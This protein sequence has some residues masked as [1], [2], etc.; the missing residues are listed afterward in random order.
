MMLFSIQVKNFLQ[1]PESIGCEI[2]SVSVKSETKLLAYHSLIYGLASLFNRVIGFIMIPVYT[3]FF[4]PSDYGMLEIITITTQVIGLVASVGVTQSIGRFYFQYEDS[5]DRNEVLSTGIIAFSL[6]SLV[7]LLPMLSLSNTLSTWLL[8]ST[9][10]SY[11]FVIAIG[12]IWFSTLNEIGFY[13]FRMLKQSIR[14]MVLSIIK[15]L[16]SILLN[17]YF[18]VVMKT[19]IIGVLYST[20]IASVIFTIILLIP[21]LNKI[22]YHFS[23]F[24]LKEMLRF[25]LPLIPSSLANMV[26]L[27]SDRYFLR[28]LATL[29]DTGLYSLAYRFSTIPGYF[30]AYPFMQVWGVRRLEIYK[31]KN[32]EEIMGKVFTYFCIFIVSVGLAVC[33][34][35]KD[36]IEM[37]S[38]PKFWPAYK[39]V[40]ILVLAQVIFSFFQHFNVGL[41]IKKKTQYFTYIDLT[42]AAVN[43]FLNYILISRYGVIGA[44]LATLISYTLR[45]IMV[46]IITMPIYKIHF[47]YIRISKLFLA[48]GL[49]YAISTFLNTPVL[50]MT[51]GIK[52]LLLFLFPVCL[53]ALR[54][55]SKPEIEKFKHIV[56]KRQFNVIFNQ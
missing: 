8:K 54:F 32:S 52:T 24:K 30:I 25:G 2:M 45:V 11:F 20:L 5:K 44:A 23:F 18:I 15:L 7:V 21:L 27:V 34:L 13:Y 14:F 6:C 53:L 43:L 31:V 3:R 40:P 35:T 19:G 12:T 51:L 50:W 42:N 9:G 10:S 56:L 26:T 37:M 39:T 48:A 46:Y 22:G 38:D 47:E 49:V 1:F 41:L 55:F 4:S 17:I 36:I 16:V 28:F 33:V 29:S